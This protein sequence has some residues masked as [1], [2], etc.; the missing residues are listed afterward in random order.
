MEPERMRG[1]GSP[2]GREAL[3]LRIIHAALLSGVLLYA[4]VVYFLIGGAEADLD[5]VATLRWVWVAVAVG[6]VFAAGIVRGRLPRGAS[7]ERR[8]TTALV[9]WA[10]AESV[11]LLGIT[12]ALV[13]GDALPL[14]GGVLVALFLFV[15]HRPPTF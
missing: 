4:A 2:H 3:L 15:Y 6:T 14:A 8:R 1:S 5:T 11:A 9:V 10:L 13:T 12:L 7:E